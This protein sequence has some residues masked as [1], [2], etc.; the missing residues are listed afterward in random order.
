MIWLNSCLMNKPGEGNC[1]WNQIC[2]YYGLEFSWLKHEP[3]CSWCQTD[4]EA[5]VLT[6]DISLVHFCIPNSGFLIPTSS[7]FRISTHQTSFSRSWVV[8]HLSF[9]YTHFSNFNFLILLCQQLGN[10][11]ILKCYFL[12]NF[13]TPYSTICPHFKFITVLI[14]CKLRHCSKIFQRFLFSEILFKTLI[15]LYT[16]F[17]HYLI[18]LDK[19]MEVINK[20]AGSNNSTVK[21]I[22]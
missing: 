22:T 14:L 4:V 20:L 3:L 19:Q 5:P 6:K 11:L 7:F 21:L 16:L 15:S 2:S 1:K 8:T 12:T 10:F 18:K 9:C 17:Y 13:L